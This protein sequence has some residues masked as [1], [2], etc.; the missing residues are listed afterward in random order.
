[1]Y[2]YSSYSPNRRPILTAVGELLAGLAVP[3]PVAKHLYGPTCPDPAM[4]FICSALVPLD[5]AY[6]LSRIVTDSKDGGDN[7]NKLLLDAILAMLSFGSNPGRVKR[8]LARNTKFVAY[9]L[10]TCTDSE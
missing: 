3:V 1:M 4:T 9:L 7:T 2:S 8:Q 10:R 6:Y 5:V